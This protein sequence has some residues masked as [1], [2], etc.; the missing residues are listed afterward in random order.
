MSDK[1]SFAKC[2]QYGRRLAA[3]LCDQ[4]FGPTPDA[5][6][7][8]PAVLR[9]TPIRQ[10]NLLVVHQLLHQWQAEIGHLRSPYF[11]FEAP[12]V[13]TALTQ[14][15]NVLSRYVRLSRSVFES[16]LAQAVADALRLAADPAN[17]FEHLFL[18]QQPVP[19][20]SQLRDTLRYL[21]L[22]K[23]FFVSFLDSLPA[24]QPLSRDSVVLRLATYQASNYQAQQPMQ[25]LIAALS[26][27]LP[28]T[29]ADLHES[30]L[31]SVSTMT[32]V[33][34]TFIAPTSTVPSVAVPSSPTSPTGALGSSIAS[35]PTPLPGRPTVPFPS[36]ETQPHQNNLVAKTPL[37]EKLK[38]T[39]PASAPLAATL[40]AT[41]STQ[42]NPLVERNTPRIETLREAVSIN[43]RFGFINELF[44]GDDTAYQ[45]A[46]QHLDSIVDQE[47]VR[48]YITQDLAQRYDWKHKE[49]HVAKLLKLVERKYAAA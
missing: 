32:T 38:A 36:A 23:D 31:V 41:S 20:P 27:L 45:V 15:Q 17:A 39:Q 40:R 44:N 18:N 28:L 30:G 3:R 11:D 49:E 2:E 42:P 33:P 25:S 34:A 5:T 4:H 7:D 24:G 8:G 46:I 35:A 12:A 29:E 47:Q 48:L 16:L 26:D 13:Q 1:Y 6:L 9:F 22:T 10:L 21:D 14:F 43:Q 37:H 19:T